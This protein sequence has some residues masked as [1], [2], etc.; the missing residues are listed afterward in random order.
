[1]KDLADILADIEAESSRCKQFI[2]EN[3]YH[4]G[5]ALNAIVRRYRKEL[6]EYRKIVLDDLHEDGIDNYQECEE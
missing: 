2:N 3:G 5:T 6:K 1:M 4:N